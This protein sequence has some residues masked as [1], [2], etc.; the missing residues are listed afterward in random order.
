MQSDQFGRAYLA[1]LYLLGERGDDLAEASGSLQSTA[2]FRA[3]TNEDRSHRAA[4][5][6]R[7]LARLALALEGGMIR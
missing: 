7:E 2:L 4:A 3:L 5:L 1:T 6:A